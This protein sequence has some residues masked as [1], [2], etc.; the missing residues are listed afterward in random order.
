M[1][2]RN[3][4]TLEERLEKHPHLKNRF[5]SLPDIVENTDGDL[6]KAN[7]AEKRVI[8]ELRTMGGELLT[9]WALNL[10]AKKVEELVLN[11]VDLSKHGKKKSFGIL[12]MER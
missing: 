12:P 8:E 9:D 3:K 6:E 10:E 4:A 1:T 7:E 11:N 5:E 2:D